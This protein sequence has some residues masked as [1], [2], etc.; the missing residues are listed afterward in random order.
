MHP[1]TFKC[2]QEK[3]T[4]L[5]LHYLPGKKGRVGLA[6]LIVGTVRQGPDWGSLLETNLSGVASAQEL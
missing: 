3:D 6:P 4:G 1:P 5:T 2:S